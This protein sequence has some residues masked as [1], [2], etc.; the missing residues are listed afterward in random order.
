MRTSEP[1][2]AKAYIAKGQYGFAFGV[3]VLRFVAVVAIGVCTSTA[4][5][6]TITA[7]STAWTA[8]HAP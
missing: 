1:D 4:L 2:V 8:L 3:M 6:K 7:A 5:P